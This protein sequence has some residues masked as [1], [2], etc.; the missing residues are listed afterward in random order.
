[1]EL[2]A[3]QRARVEMKDYPSGHMIYL[4]LNNRH[5][6]TQDI[7]KF[8]ARALSSTQAQRQN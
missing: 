1:M 2:D 7:E 6:L 8:F 3:A 4:S 5:R